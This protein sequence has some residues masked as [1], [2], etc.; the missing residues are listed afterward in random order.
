MFL[1][2]LINLKSNNKLI[3]KKKRSKW[4]L[5]P[6]CLL[7]GAKRAIFVNLAYKKCLYLSCWNIRDS[8]LISFMKNSNH[9]GQAQYQPQTPGNIFTDRLRLPSVNS[10]FISPLRIAPSPYINEPSFFSNGHSSADLNH[11][12]L[13]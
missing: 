4:F 7:L 1:E 12:Q 5:F 11:F 2:L 6:N 13:E 10:P 9:Q 8:N 3:S